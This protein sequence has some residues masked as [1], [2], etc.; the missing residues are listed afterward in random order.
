[1]IEDWVSKGSGRPVASSKAQLSVR[2]P[3]AGAVDPSQPTDRSEGGF[4]RFPSDAAERAIQLV[5]RLAGP[6]AFLL[7]LGGIVWIIVN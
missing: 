3:E 7:A 2:P 6:L 4:P 5:S 1:M